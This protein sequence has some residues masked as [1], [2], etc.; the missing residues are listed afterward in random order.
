[1]VRL[2]SLALWFSLAA[3][4]FGQ[5]AVEAGLGA[6]RAATSTAPA[7]GLGKSIGGL[8]GRLDKALKPAQK[9]A[10]EAPAANSPA[11]TAS[12]A[13]SSAKL[14]PKYE[15]AEAIEPGLPYAD[16]IRRFGPPAMS[17]TFDGE[18]TLSYSG[19]VGPYQVK[20]VA[21]KVKAVEQPQP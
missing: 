4:A 16:L 1:M 9:D 18:T 2:I 20:V 12:A 11:P 8:A 19:K 5:A 7:K 14:A 21:G 6:S 17:M 15:D 13:A 10:E 3:S